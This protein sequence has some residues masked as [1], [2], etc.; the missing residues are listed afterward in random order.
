MKVDRVGLET[1]TFG[2]SVPSLLQLSYRSDNG[3]EAFDIV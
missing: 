3:T 2:I 1:T